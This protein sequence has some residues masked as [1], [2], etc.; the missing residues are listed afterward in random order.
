M[1][2]PYEF[3]PKNRRC[4]LITI[5]RRLARQLRAIFRDIFALRSKSAPCVVTLETGPTGLDIWASSADAAARWHQPGDSPSE[6]LRLP[7]RFLADCEAAKDGPV[8]IESQGAKSVMVR[9]HDAKVPQVAQYCLESPPQKQELPAAPQ[10]LAENGPQLLWALAEA[11]ETA[12]IEAIR[13]ATSCLRLRGGAGTIAATDGRQFLLQGGF[14]FPW[15]GDLLIPRSAVFGCRELPSGMP[16]AIGKS[17]KWMV[18]TV[19]AWTFWLAINTTGRYPSVDHLLRPAAAAKAH[20]RLSLGDVC[21]VKRSLPKLPRDDLHNSPV[22]VELNGSIA[23]RAKGQ[24]AA[25]PTELV[26]ARSAWSGQPVRMQMNRMYLARA[27]ELGFSELDFFE[28]QSPIVARGGTRS[29]VWAPL[30]PDSAIQPADD[31]VRIVSDS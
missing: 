1:D 14:H 12:D 9:W 29:Y 21:F 10:T 7:Y 4:T 5:T 25:Q 26:L 22:T 3:V 17:D 23:V 11:S 24:T 13:F 31:A 30:D 19:G 6:R 18:F 20:C 16:V 2:V 8:E 27:F 15:E 28:P